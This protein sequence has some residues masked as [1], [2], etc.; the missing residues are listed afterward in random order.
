M[1]KKI[2]L[3]LLLIISIIGIVIS[4]YNIILWKKDNNIV[5]EQ[6]E[7]QKKE[8]EIKEEII[9]DKEDNNFNIKTT[10][11]NDNS[12]QKNN[13]L[14]F[15]TVNIKNLQQTN[16]D[17]KGWIKVNGTNI[18]YSFVQTDNNTFYLKHSVDK[19][20]SKA[21][22]VFMDFRNELEE[23]DKNTIFYAHGRADGSM[24][25][26]LR[27]TLKNDW[28]KDENNHYVKITTEYN[29]TI[30]KV[31]SVYSINKTSDY[32]SVNFSNDYDNFL[33]MITD[34]SIY[35]FKEDLNEN[36]KII[37]LSTCQNSTVRIV[38]HA[39]LIKIETNN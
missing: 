3:T 28:L 12:N 5:E 15:L 33:K 18:N 34:R 35:N 38:L 1:I 24:F 32:L 8:A 21:G 29:K 11:K 30:W 22:W 13:V 2:I 20:Y 9:I 19:S 6:V 39:K 16:P 27:K 14:S 36:D 25:G 31:F 10:T 23:L 7:E 26:S 37:T 4:S 17:I